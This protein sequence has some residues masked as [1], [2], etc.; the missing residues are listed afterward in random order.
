MNT[1]SLGSSRNPYPWHLSLQNIG[2][3]GRYGAPLTGGCAKSPKPERFLSPQYTPQPRI[4]KHS[5]NLSSGGYFDSASPRAGGMIQ[6]KMAVGGSGNAG[7]HLIPWRGASFSQDWVEGKAGPGGTRPRSEENQKVNLRPN[8][9]AKPGL[10]M[11]DRPNSGSMAEDGRPPP[12]PDPR[13]KE[14]NRLRAVF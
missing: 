2:Q 7:R 13:F 10:K 9:P 14:V 3:V 8:L 4:R 12:A 1:L 5:K 6:S 11:S